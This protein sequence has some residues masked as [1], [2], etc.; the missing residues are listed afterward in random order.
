MAEPV[1][2]R[3]AGWGW[4]LL[5][6]ANLGAALFIGLMAWTLGQAAAPFEAVPARPHL[7]AAASGARAAPPPAAGVAAATRAPTGGEASPDWARP[8]ELSPHHFDVPGR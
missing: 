7:A 3:H 6:V 2:P 4:L 5:A 8:A 1:K